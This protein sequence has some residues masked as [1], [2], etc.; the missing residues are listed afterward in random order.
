MI[1]PRLKSRLFK[2][3]RW[4]GLA[5]MPLFLLIALSGMVLAFKP[6]LATDKADAATTSV[7][8]P[9]SPEKVGAL[10]DTIDPQ[11][12]KVGAVRVDPRHNTLDVKSRDQY[13][14]GRYD[15]ASGD[16]LQE[17]AE[18]DGGDLFEIA[19][20][21]HKG[22]LLDA[23]L[24]TQIAAYLM[25]GM[26]L[27][28]PLLAWPRFKANLMGWHRTLGWGLLPLLLMLPLSG[29]LMSL[30]VGMPEVPGMH[31]Q[32]ARQPLSLSGALRRA[33]S[34]GL[35]NLSF[36]RRLPNAAILLTAGTGA[37][38]RM[39]VVTTQAV[40]AIDPRDNLVKS[41]HEGTWA[42][43][44]SGTLNLIGAAA[45]SL[46]SF[47]GFISWLSRARKRRRAATR[48]APPAV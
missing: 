30:H 47:T 17:Q 3:H 35:D 32:E 31:E 37:S 25:L 6:I 46:L 9:V 21:L 7:V 14:A 18:D 13:L 39:L 36:A 10:L 26:I 27:V 38:Q 12:G 16:K 34:Q 43:S 20:H 1:S 8:A 5:L 48:T 33:A 45:L 4:T 42:G 44:L 2:L 11:G 23:D 15:L 29:I 19:E 28:A 41:L 40:T 22:L 24:L